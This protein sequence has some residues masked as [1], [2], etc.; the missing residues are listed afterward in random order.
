MRHDLKAA[1]TALRQRPRLAMSLAMDAVFSI[2][3]GACYWVLIP[4]LTIDILGGGLTAYPWVIEAVSGGGLIG[5]VIGG[6]VRWRD[7]TFVVALGFA[8]AGLAFA[9]M[10]LAPSVHAVVVL[11][12]I[13]GLAMAVENVALLSVLHEFCPSNFLGTVFSFWRVSVE[14]AG[15]SGML[16]GGL[17]ADLLPPGL[18]ALAFGLYVPI[19]MM[20]LMCGLHLI[21]ARIENR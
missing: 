15:V 7:K 2:A 14:A 20:V 13:V 9:L 1:V 19:V 21:E 12:A 3:Y 10:W 16:I 8:V 5:G 18:L 17:A 11:G 6:I 4:R